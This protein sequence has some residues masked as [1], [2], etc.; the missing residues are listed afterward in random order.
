[1]FVSSMQRSCALAST[2]FI[3]NETKEICK[4][5]R[6]SYM[7]KETSS[8]T[9]TGS[10]PATISTTTTTTT[11]TSSPNSSM[12]ML[13][14]MNEVSS[15]K[16]RK[17]DHLQDLADSND[18]DHETNTAPNT[19]ILQ[20]QTSQ[21]GDTSTLEARMKA[22]QVLTLPQ[23]KKQLDECSEMY[24]DLM[25]TLISLVRKHVLTKQHVLDECKEFLDR[26]LQEPHSSITENEEELAPSHNKRKNEEEEEDK[27]EE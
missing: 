20:D 7:L 19:S 24:P 21:R 6:E 3:K 18:D 25:Q 13:S 11:R 1:M 26:N 5:C 4:T 15:P 2:T 27:E 9:T 16:K 10:N 23:L 12:S 14:S 8:T 17:F 22:T